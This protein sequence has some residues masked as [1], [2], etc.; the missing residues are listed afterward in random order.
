MPLVQLCTA[1]CLSNAVVIKTVLERHGIT[2]TVIGVEVCPQSPI[3]SRLPD[4][5]PVLVSDA[6]FERAH[7]ILASGDVR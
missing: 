6:D 2:A 5:V 7:D 3:L 1:T 4:G